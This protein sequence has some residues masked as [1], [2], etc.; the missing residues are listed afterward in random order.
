MGRHSATSRKGKHR[1]PSRFETFLRPTRSSLKGNLLPLALI[2]L[3]G[4]GVTWA[5][6][7]GTKDGLRHQ[8]RIARNPFIYPCGDVLCENGKIFTPQPKVVCSDALKDPRVI[9]DEAVHDRQ[10]TI[11][12]SSLVPPKQAK[13]SVDMPN[14]LRQVDD[15]IAEA[16]KSH[17]RVILNLS[18]LVLR[19]S[20]TDTHQAEAQWKNTVDSTSTHV[21]GVTGVGYAQDPT[22]MMIKLSPVEQCSSD[23]PDANYPPLPQVTK[24][25]KEA[26]PRQLVEP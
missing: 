14:V 19:L 26:F 7:E 16:Q 22:I 18:D 2:A 5:F 6:N 12:I 15:T 13:E 24:L 8:Q 4:I 11:E 20:A 25:T 10:N 3:T 9:V 17:L 23:T 1:A 21:N